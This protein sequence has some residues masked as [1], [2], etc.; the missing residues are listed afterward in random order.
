MNKKCI[1]DCANCTKDNGDDICKIAADDGKTKKIE[2]DDEVPDICYKKGYFKE[3]KHKTP[4]FD[5]S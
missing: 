1:D 4:S 2:S 3:K 5:F